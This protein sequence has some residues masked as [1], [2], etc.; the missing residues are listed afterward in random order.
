MVLPEDD[1]WD[2]ARQPWELSV[3]QRPSAVVHVCSVN[4]VQAAV[5]AVAATSGAAIAAQPR[6][7]G[8]TTALDGAVLLRTGSLDVLSVDPARRTARIGAGVAWGRVMAALDGTGL[9]ALA[10]SHPGVT[11]VPY[12]LGGGLSWFSRAFGVGATSVRAAE[13]VDATGARRRIDPIVGPDLLWALRGGGGDFGIVTEIEVDLFPAPSLY[14]GRLVFPDE[15]AAAV[16]AA[17]A[18]VTGAAPESFTAWL[19]RMHLPSQSPAGSGQSFLFVDV[20]HLGPPEEAEALLAPV[21]AAGPVPR[22]TMRVL[23]PSDVGTVAEEP[24]KGMPFSGTTVPLSVLDEE[25]REAVLR[26]GGRN[27]GV[28]LVAIRH[29]GGAIRREHTEGT[30]S[31][32]GPADPDGRS[33]CG[34]SVEAEYMLMAMTWA[35]TRSAMGR[36]RSSVAA[37]A[38]SMRPWRTGGSVLSFLTHDAPL[39][40]AF[41]AGE[42]Q[43]TP[44]DQAGGRPRRRLPQQPP[45]SRSVTEATRRAAAS[46]RAIDGDFE[47]QLEQGAERNVSVIDGGAW[48]ARFENPDPPGAVAYLKVIAWERL[49]L[50]EGGGPALR[51]WLDGA[52]PFRSD[53]LPD[54]LRDGYI[55]TGYTEQPP[56]EMRA[57]LSQADH[58]VTHLYGEVGDP[59][60]VLLHGLTE[61]GT[62]WPDAVRRWA[63]RWHITAPDLRGHGLSPR[64]RHEEVARSMDIFVA[65]LMD[66]LPKNRRPIVVA[67]SL[68]G[69]VALAVALSNPGRVR[70]LVLEE[71]ALTDWDLAPADF[72][73][74][75]EHLLDAYLGD[76][77]EGQCAR[78]R[79]ESSWT[80][81]EIAACADC[82]PLVDRFL[83]RN[84]RMGGIDAVEALNAVRVP[85]LLILSEGSQVVPEPWRVT[86]PWVRTETIRDAGHCVRRDN[87][88]GYHQVVDRFLDE[89]RAA[90]EA[91]EHCGPGAAPLRGTSEG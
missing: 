23:D 65:D 80:E 89:H 46:M 28:N 63:G 37:L 69:R 77:R 13:L 4:D 44:G 17:Y 9:V 73:A 60:L 36:A 90:S 47:R 18:R 86:N 20:V 6:G 79:A 3:D 33:G 29:L 35:P 76:G 42:H 27:S 21:R 24:E 72:V 43:Q 58:I 85:T 83:V 68:G 66:T 12:L 14:G 59:A 45:G 78:L 64:F 71:P 26:S 41:T 10:G 62:A 31:S 48:Y 82:K 50:P 25:A 55:L 74:D 19:S 32:G 30:P 87:A 88:A 7:H 91:S 8:A 61:A 39:S 52:E 34:T 22:E 15:A 84:L 5:R 49:D 56:A 57:P 54:H 38:D 70:A 1:G 2:V 51:A 75:Q 40:E 67:H 16:L 11:A 53:R 81:E